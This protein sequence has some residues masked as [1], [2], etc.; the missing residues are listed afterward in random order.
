MIVCLHEDEGDR[1]IDPTDKESDPNLRV[2]LGLAGKQ[3]LLLDWDHPRLVQ[4]PEYPA[5]SNTIDVQRTLRIDVEGAVQAD[6]RISYNGYYA[7]TMRR[8]F[9]A[10]DPTR[11]K[12]VWQANVGGESEIDIQDLGV[13][14][15]EDRQRSV[16]LSLKYRVRHAMHSVDR[17]YVGQLPAPWEAAVLAADRTDHRMAPLWLHFPLV[18]KATINIE[19]PAGYA[20]PSAASLAIASKAGLFQCQRTAVAEPNGLRLQCEASRPAGH[21]PPA[22]YTEYVD[23]V[24]QA[25]LIFTPDL[26]LNQREK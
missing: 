19:P 12:T 13:E 26:V 14:G 24:E 18:V 22:F 8:Y 3:A 21:F 20:L 25:R 17:Q 6:D 10:I 16:V 7:S 5:G 9:K 15:L 2:P 1:F 23:Q 4:I 11:R